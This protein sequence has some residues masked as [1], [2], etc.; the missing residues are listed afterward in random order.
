MFLL[1]CANGYHEVIY[2]EVHRIDKKNNLNLPWFNCETENSEYSPQIVHFKKSLFC[3]G[4]N[5]EHFERSCVFLVK[6]ENELFLMKVPFSLRSCFEVT[7]SKLTIE[8]LEQGVRYVQ[9]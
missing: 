3:S 2:L 8:T 9:N 4:G 7:C 5:L 6:D 1:P